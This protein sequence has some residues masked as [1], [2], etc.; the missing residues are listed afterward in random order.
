[1]DRVSSQSD[2]LYLLKFGN[3]LKYTIPE[4]SVKLRRVKVQRI[5]GS[6]RELFDAFL[7][8]EPDIEIHPPACICI[9]VIESCVVQVKSLL[10]KFL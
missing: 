7:N 3:T 10:H 8:V 6:E 9:E 4:F 1:M 2:I 5:C